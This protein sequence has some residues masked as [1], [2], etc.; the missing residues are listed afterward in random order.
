[1]RDFNIRNRI[2]GGTALSL[3]LTAPLAFAAP[4]LAADPAPIQTQGP[5][6]AQPPAD[7]AT[8]EIDPEESGLTEQETA[9]VEEIVST[10]TSI[11]GVKA[12]GSETV[13]MTK[14]EI[15]ATGLT[16]IGQVLNT[17][18]QFQNFAPGG[19]Q[20][21]SPTV[22]DNAA[23]ATFGGNQ[24]G[25]T[26]INLRGLGN[27]ATLVLIDG[28]RA[29]PSGGESVVDANQIPLAALERVEI[30]ADGASAVYGSDAVAGVVNY[31]LRKDYEGVEATARYTTQT[32]SHTAGGSITI[33]RKW[34]LWAGGSALITYDHEV[35]SAMA[36]NSNPLFRSDKRPVG[37]S[38]SIGLNGSTAPISTQPYITRVACPPGQTVVP[39]GSPPLFRSVS[40]CQNAQGVEVPGTITAFYFAVTPTTGTTVPTLAQVL[41]SPMPTF[42]TPSDYTDQLGR[43]ERHSGALYVR[44]DLTDDIQLSGHI[45]YQTR[46]D[47][48]RAGLINGGA[49]ILNPNAANPVVPFLIPGIPGAAPPGPPTANQTTAYTVR[50]PL[51]VRIAR[52]ENRSLNSA[53]GLKWNL[54]KEWAADVGYAYTW[55]DDQGGIQSREDG[56]VILAA[57]Q[58]RN[59]ANGT[60][61]PYSVTNSDSVMAQMLGS[62]RTPNTDT[63]HNV[64]IK[65]D[66]PL[67][68]LPGGKVRAA[69]GG[70]WNNQEATRVQI[71]TVAST[72]T[73]PVLT[74]APTLGPSYPSQE[75]TS[76]F[77][78]LFVPI[79]SADNAMTL[80][81]T[82]T[83]N[84][85]DRYDD[86][87]TFGGTENPRVGLTYRPIEDLVLRGS[88]GTS[89]RSPGLNVGT[90]NPNDV[91]ILCAPCST[92]PVPVF[93]IV[94][95]TTAPSPYAGL[96]ATIPYI[97]YV[98]RSNNLL[99]ETSTNKQWGFDYDPSWLPG[100]R[101]S[102]TMYDID[103]RNKIDSPDFA[104][105]LANNAVAQGASDIIHILQ[106]NI[107]NPSACV[108][109]NQATYDPVLVDVIGSETLAFFDARGATPNTGFCTAKLIVDGRIGNTASQR[110][111]GYDLSVLYSFNTDLGRFT[112]NAS[113]TKITSIEA[114]RNG[115]D[116]VL[117]PAVLDFIGGPL[118]TR[119]R[120]GLRWDGGP[121]SINLFANHV[122]SYVN[123]RPGIANGVQLAKYTIPSHTTFDLTVAYTTGDEAPDWAQ[124]VRASVSFINV[125]DE[126]PPYALSTQGQVYDSSAADPYGRIVNFNVTKAF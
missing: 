109:G 94:N 105:V 65:F 126:D 50:F 25:N 11:R 49:A 32:G 12:V 71:S 77:A 17:L 125:T 87:S 78:E 2:L 30:V 101:V 37:G 56:Y 55:S 54:P 13:T 51:G 26:G 9:E 34:G 15:K 29:A 48:R 115:S 6:A 63:S 119:A 96:G 47:E 4:A 28:R 60:F 24:S 41:A 93:T 46:E 40:Y 73:P 123:N 120:A 43:R 113:V 5:A 59:L 82:L 89:F 68:E 122:G 20:E 114:R 22:S 102:G 57:V 64:K 90:T 118:D 92:I 86:Y 84:L 79:V 23:G 33:G 117:L 70:E 44:Q 8:D 107:S 3:I 58:A 66:G 35:R 53:I 91:N 74:Y 31:V 19:N 27:D 39:A 83:L 116:G 88:W 62:G 67:F 85:S 75:I 106:Q 7:R 100:L 36:S 61:N 110:Q 10:G 45:T 81:Q 21:T 121:W 76:A 16:N 38:S 124:G 69:I 14:E 104:A 97:A 103:Y 95:S 18:P 99:P 42:A 1:M 112:A 108:P 98:G 72:S 111:R 52:A 80:I